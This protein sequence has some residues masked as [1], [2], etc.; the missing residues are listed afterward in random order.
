MSNR[1]HFPSADVSK[2]IDPLTHLQTESVTFVANVGFIR[3]ICLSD[4]DDIC[5]PKWHISIWILS[6]KPLLDCQS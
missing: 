2:T 5:G 1:A 6:I 4:S 3:Q